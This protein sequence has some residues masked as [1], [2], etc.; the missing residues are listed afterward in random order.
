[1]KEYYTLQEIADRLEI[2]PDRILWEVERK[3]INAV[4][5][6]GE[7]QIPMVE[8]NRIVRERIFKPWVCFGSTPESLGTSSELEEGQ[9]TGPGSRQW[10]P[11]L[12]AEGDGIRCNRV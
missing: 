10:V 12:C 6:S 9:N 8:W 2:K 1:M 4:N 7:W 3:Q 11:V 5:V